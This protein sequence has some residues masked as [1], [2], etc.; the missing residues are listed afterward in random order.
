MHHHLDSGVSEEK[1]STEYISSFLG[2]HYRKREIDRM[3]FL[4]IRVD[5]R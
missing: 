3:N 2:I 5:Y 4:R 1:V